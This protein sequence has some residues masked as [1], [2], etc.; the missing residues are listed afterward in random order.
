MEA[1]QAIHGGHRSATLHGCIRM[2][3]HTA[4]FHVNGQNVWW[5]K[6]SDDCENCGAMATTADSEGVPLCGKCANLP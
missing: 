6:S 5:P 2:M 3:G 4:P 1:C